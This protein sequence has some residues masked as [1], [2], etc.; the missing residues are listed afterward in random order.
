M[1]E[2]NRTQSTRDRGRSTA[3]PAYVI[4]LVASAGGLNALSTILR[5]LPSDLAAA[6]VV[7]LHQDPDRVSTIVDILERHSTMPMTVAVDAQQLESGVVVVI[8]PGSHLLVKP[9]A[10][11]MLISSGAFPPSRPSADLLLATLATAAGKNAIAVV[12]SGLGIAPLL[13][14]LTTKPAASP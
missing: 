9:G 10:E 3:E 5:A 2:P 1:P 11:V 8:P 14:A 12:L 4:A 6:I 13:A 7:L